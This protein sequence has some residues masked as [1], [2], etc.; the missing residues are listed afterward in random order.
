VTFATYAFATHIYV[1]RLGIRHNCWGKA[2]DCFMH[3]LLLHRADVWAG[4]YGEITDVFAFWF[5]ARM[6][7]VSTVLPSNI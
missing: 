7:K 2:V 6:G 5:S 3:H 4:S 1:A